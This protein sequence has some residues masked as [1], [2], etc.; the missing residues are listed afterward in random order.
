MLIIRKLSGIC[1]LTALVLGLVILLTACQ[2]TPAD[3]TE[4]P[5]E[6]GTPVGSADAIEPV[7]PTPTVIHD[8]PIETALASRAFTEGTYNDVITLTTGLLTVSELPN[9]TNLE[10][11]LARAYLLTNQPQPAL[12]ILIPLANG[13]VT[14]QDKAIA[15]GLSAQAYE[16]NGQWQEALTA[17]QN[18]YTMLPETK[19]DVLWHIARL[20]A[21]AGDYA[22]AA[23]EYQQIDPA[24]FSSTQQAELLEETA[25]ALRQTGAY[26][27][28]IGL[29]DTI[30]G[31]AHNTAYRALVLYWKG[32]TLLQAERLDDASAVLQLAYQEDSSSSAAYLALQSLKEHDRSPYSALEE[33]WVYFYN[34]QYEASRQALSVFYVA[35]GAETA[36]TSYLQGLLAEYTGDYEVALRFYEQTILTDTGGYYLPEAWLAKAR[37]LAA[38]NMNPVETY[39]NFTASFPESPYAATALWRSALYSQSRGDWLAAEQDYLSL[40]QHFPEHELAPEAGFRAGL[41][42]YAATEVTRAQEQW[43]QMLQA[44][45][46]DAAMSNR[47]T[48]W[49]GVA[50][51]RLTGYEDAFTYWTEVAAENPDGYYGLRAHDQLTGADLQ[52]D[53]QSA[54]TNDPHSLSELEWQNLYAWVS[55]WYTA[56]SEI[57]PVAD[58]TDYR[59]ALDLWEIGW[60]SQSLAVWGRLHAAYQDSPTALLNLARVA[61]QLGAYSASIDYANEII[62]LAWAA[63]QANLPDELWRLVHPAY[64]YDLVKHESS[65]VGI[66]SLLLMALLKQESMFNA[67]ALSSAG[68]EGMAQI[69]PATAE[70]IASELGVSYDPAQLI[71]PRI[72]IRFG[73]WYL[74]QALR[75]F[76]GSILPGLAAYNAGPGATQNWL[77]MLSFKDDDLF[78]ELVPY[79]E[80][81]AYLSQ[82]YRNYRIY[83]RL[84][85]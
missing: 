82:V 5:A 43:G 17:Y 28:A 63:G 66:D 14:N 20:S 50:A 59:R 70:Y 78:F 44:G 29:Y 81:R 10:L 4:T 25:T 27:E 65:G 54:I 19:P 33:A 75:L 16:A 26:T 47:L 3:L 8:I 60:K 62:D 58:T 34:D 35:G 71:L 64:Y 32:D 7:E 31:F 56:T 21:R 52:T 6:P 85:K 40:W 77:S 9:R 12:D 57:T 2:D 83:Q 24:S 74:A 55:T 67:S 39:R 61:E 76:D 1:V 11:L 15:T 72:S 69:M 53:T 48:Y 30:L 51:L 42:A 73:A 18:Y 46:T 79:A 37:T 80:T 38:N 13:E 23:E 41:M 68:A 45:P 36:E 49:L 84:A 22:R